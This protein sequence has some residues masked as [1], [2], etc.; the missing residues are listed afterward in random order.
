MVTKKP[1][2]GS[3]SGAGGLAMNNKQMAGFLAEFV[4]SFVNWSL[5]VEYISII[6]FYPMGFM[7]FT[8]M[9]AFL[10]MM[11]TPLLLGIGPISQLVGYLNLYLRLIAQLMAFAALY[12]TDID[13]KNVEKHE[14]IL[15]ENLHVTKTVFVG[16]ALA[17]DWLC[18][19]RTF[20]GA[21][22][23]STAR[24][25]RTAYAYMVAIIFHALMRLPHLS[26]N[27]F[28]TWREYI[29]FGVFLV[30]VSFAILMRE[31]L[32]GDSEES[33][34][35]RPTLED[36]PCPWT[37]GIGFGGVLFGCQLLLSTYGL[38]PRW[39]NLGPFPAGIVIIVMMMAGF[40]ISKKTSIVT[41]RNYF[42]FAIFCGAVFGWCSGSVPTVIG[43]VGLVSGG[44]VGVYL[45]SL[46]VVTLENVANTNKITK[47]FIATFITYVVLLFWAIYKF[48][49]WWLGST[50]LRERNQT[51]IIAVIL[52][53]GFGALRES[54]R[55][56]SQKKELRSPTMGTT[57]YPSKESFYTIFGML[58]LL[59]L[60]SVNR[61]LSHPTQASVAGHHYKRTLTTT[62]VQNDPPTEIKSM[63]WTIHFGYDNYGRNSFPNITQAIASHGAN[64]IGLL[65]SD[66]SRVMTGNR[67][68]VEYLASELHMHSDFGPAPSENTWGCA[69][70]SIFPIERSKHVILPSP[71][72]ELACLIDAVIRVDDTEVN[73]IVT[74]FGNTEDVIDR[75]LQ[76]AGAAEIV[77]TNNMPTVFLSYITEKTGGDNYKTLMASG[78]QDT[79]NERRY[80]EYVFYR[81]LEMTQFKRWGCGEISDTEGQLTNFKVKKN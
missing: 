25:E 76:A 68:L 19:C 50:L 69:L 72:G 28:V 29:I 12:P 31:K 44:L 65:E 73:V 13:P 22:S 41:S 79:T 40:A 35:R 3:G 58:I 10:V 37:T 5:F 59:V 11:F 63:I 49:P 21:N 9:E 62:T 2:H 46:W 42:F 8:G 70:L 60:F 38:I 26:I 78:L 36:G 33:A 51:M 43:F 45:M 61:S 47:L 56:T 54:I 53:A 55:P 20:I 75:K 74:H 67:D 77:K 57:S 15:F 17:I 14:I 80:C 66:L 64:V 23:I 16:A 4:M 71:E 48:V 52:C 30:V 34:R 7:G 39:V 27:P 6:W 32:A 1:T 81:D 18:Q 24:R